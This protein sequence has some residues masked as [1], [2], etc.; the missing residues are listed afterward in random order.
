MGGCPATARGPR[1]RPAATPPHQFGTNDALPFDSSERA[2]RKAGWEAG[3]QEGE[4]VSAGRIVAV[5]AGVV[6]GL[7]AIGFLIGG[8]FLTVGYAVTAEDDGYF[9]T[10]PKRFGSPA[11]AV[12]TEEAEL[13]ADPAPPDWLWDFV[14]FSVR[15]R[16][17]GF[18]NEVFL[19]VGSQA[20]V[21]A[22]LGSAAYDQVREIRPGQ[23]VQYR[24]IP[25]AGTVEPPVDQDFWVAEASGS[26]PQEVVWD[27]T[28]GTWVVVL[29][30]ADGSPGVV[31]DVAVGAKSGVVLPL[32]MALLVSG[33]FLFVIAVLI[34]V[35]A[36]VVGRGSE[37]ADR[38]AAGVPQRFPEP[39]RVEAVID[40]PLS[41]WLWLVK[42]FLAIPHLIVL[43]FLWIAFVAL[44][45]IAWW[46]ILFTG[47]Y[48]EGLFRFNVGVMRWSWRVGY[49]AGGGGLG[50]DRYPP[51]TL[52]DVPDYPARFDVAY[53]EHLSRGLVLVKWWLLAIPQYIVVGVMVGGTLAWGADLWWGGPM[54]AGG[55]IGALVLIAAVILLFTGRYP[56]PL[57][58][59]IIG[60][61]RWV[62]RV[63][64]YACLMTDRYPPFRLDQ[65]GKEPVTTETATD[66]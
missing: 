35:L 16:V 65:G 48:P 57:F 66:R 33:L 63:A 7:L 40:T 8:A 22:Y 3:N 2:Q 17:V 59:F 41:Q 27:V 54:W 61:N 13:A 30:N 36:A 24:S 58:D 26:G 55:L 11:F 29:M 31:A 46:A 18:G 4:I 23:S 14:D 56:E 50:T 21:E 47:R 64:A 52:E 53:P 38:E 44:T 5:I 39:V 12:T 6:V 43:A 37:I 25:G 19:G 42:W 45:F 9:D 10:S 60:L 20:D 51:F 62:L 1:G 49:Y 34:I 32:G 15:F 28:E